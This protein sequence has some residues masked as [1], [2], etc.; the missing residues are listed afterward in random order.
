MDSFRAYFYFEAQMSFYAKETMIKHLSL[1]VLAAATASFAVDVE[2]HGEIDADYASYWDKDFSPTNAA[3]QDIKLESKVF[4]DENVSVSIQGR[5]HSNYVSENGTEASQVRH[6]N[7]ATA[8]GD[9]ENRWTGFNFDGVSLA[10]QFT[11]LARIVFGDLTY[12]AG[13]FSYYYWRDTEDY[14]VILRDQSI[15][16]IGFEV[17]NGKAYIGATENNSHS[18]AA[19]ITYGFDL[20]SKTEE[21]FTITPSLDW[22]FG[23]EIGRSYTYALGTEIQYAKSSDFFSYGINAT[24]GTHPYKGHGVH[25][26]LVE[27]SFN[28]KFF[29]IAASYYQAL[30]AEKDSSVVDQ[31]FTEDERMFYIEPSLDLHKKFSM[32]FAYEFHDP[33]TEQHNDSR[34]FVGPSFYLYPTVEAEIIFWAGYNICSKGANHFSMGMSGH[35]EF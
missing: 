23:K 31:T 19:F 30:L 26:F 5:T 21:R 8:M 24:W 9:K 15:R 33:S 12:N 28:Y 11:P 18:L 6:E 14:A 2:L 3:N 16:G 35:V 1:F 7:R 27:P 4:L 10:W 13:S 17:E 22:V 29:N 25:T 34:H 32:G 20:I